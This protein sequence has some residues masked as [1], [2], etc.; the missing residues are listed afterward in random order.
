MKSLNTLQKIFQ[1]FKTLSRVAMI[2]SFVVAG[3][4]LLGLSC[5]MVWRSGG[6]VVG[7]QLD[8]LISLTDTSGFNQ[9]IGS[10]L[11]DTVFALTD[12]ILFLLAF[13]YFSAELA[14]G[15]PFTRSGADHI[16]RLGIQTIVLPLV[17]VIVSSVIC[18]CFELPHPEDWSN[19]GSVSLGIVLIL[20]SLVFRYGAELE[21]ARKQ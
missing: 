11:S 10:L 12:G 1:V 15:T 14:D 4:A 18:S 3:L 6:T 20:A 19:S 17:G 21:E 2:L 7:V 8:T 5:A 9:M 16:K 13:R